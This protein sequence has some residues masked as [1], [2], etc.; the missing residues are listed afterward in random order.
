[1]SVHTRTWCLSLGWQTAAASQRFFL[2]SLTIL[3]PTSTSFCRVVVS[4]TPVSASKEHPRSPISYSRLRHLTS[5]R[6]KSKSSSV[7]PSPALRSERQT[8]P[9]FTTRQHGRGSQR[10]VPRRG[11]GNPRRSQP[12]HPAEHQRHGPSGLQRLKPCHGGLLRSQPRPGHL[13]VPLFVVRAAPAV[14]QRLVRS[15]LRRVQSVGL[16]ARRHQLHRCRWRAQRYQLLI[17]R[18][19]PRGDR[20][21][22]EDGALGSPRVG[23]HILP[24]LATTNPFSEENRYC[25]KFWP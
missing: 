13:G 22:K 14:L 4:A 7:Q 24:A 21:G 1:M 23:V 2:F 9:S 8:S 3:A 15:R 11:L 10:D 20:H 6:N 12:A 19:S 5:R 16:C 25:F 17:Q 18:G